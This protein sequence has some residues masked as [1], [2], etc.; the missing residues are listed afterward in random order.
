MITLRA[1]SASFASPAAPSRGPLK[2]CYIEYA[3]DGVVAKPLEDDEVAGVD[4]REP[5]GRALHGAFRANQGVS[6]IIWR[7]HRGILPIS[8]AYGT[9]ADILPAIPA[10]VYRIIAL[11]EMMGKWR[12]LHC[13]QEI[14]GNKPFSAAE[15]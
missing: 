4:R 13:Y 14:N 2:V 11:P 6:A 3:L 1:G 8:G 12:I 9:H 7:W 15:M 10:V 5:H